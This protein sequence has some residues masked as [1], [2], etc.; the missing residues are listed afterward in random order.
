MGAPI[1]A[2]PCDTLLFSLVAQPDT[3]LF[4][5]SSNVWSEHATVE[6][7]PALAGRTLYRETDRQF[8]KP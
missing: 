8:A 6:S 3:R 4:P 5:I 2:V 1:L 7:Y